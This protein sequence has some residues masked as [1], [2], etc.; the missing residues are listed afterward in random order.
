MKKIIICFMITCLLFSLCACGGSTNVAITLKDGTSKNMTIAELNKWKEEYSGREAAEFEEQI[1]EA[2][3]SGTGKVVSVKVDEPFSLNGSTR[4][5]NR[6]P[7][8]V[9]LDNG[10]I[11]DITLVYESE[12][13][14]YD[15]PN[16]NY[17]DD[18]PKV[19]IYEKDNLS[20][21]GTISADCISKDTLKVR[22]K[23]SEIG[24]FEKK[25]GLDYITGVELN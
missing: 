20:F 21:S 13:Y 23:T 22:I 17:P 8:T 12:G 15:N 10:I 2:T 16:Y 24:K 18:I 14:A 7:C 11:L 9:T 4:K 19:D 1:A 5:G 6:F 3:V 25:V